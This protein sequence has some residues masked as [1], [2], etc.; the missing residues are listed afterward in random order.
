MGEATIE[1]PARPTCGPIM[2]A[3]AEGFSA[4]DCS[5]MDKKTLR[6][7]RQK[8]TLTH[9]TSAASKRQQANPSRA[10]P[11]LGCR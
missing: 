6:R 2:A 5:S 7:E 1:A 8:E 4:T 3:R 10:T 9:P 11:T